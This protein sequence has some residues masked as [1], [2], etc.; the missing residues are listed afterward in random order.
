MNPDYGNE[1]QKKNPWKLSVSKGFLVRV[2][3][4]EPAAS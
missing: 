3:G 2:T 1:K 4:L